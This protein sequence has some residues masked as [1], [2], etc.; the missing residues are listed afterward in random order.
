MILAPAGLQYTESDAFPPCLLS[1]NR[2]LTDSYSISSYGM[3]YKLYEK[4]E[5]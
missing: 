1:C 5:D 3:S 4:N 2:A